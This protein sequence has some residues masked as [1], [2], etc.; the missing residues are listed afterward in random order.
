MQLA[1]ALPPTLPALILHGTKD[2]QISLDD[3]NNVLRGFQTAG[4]TRAA[5]FELANVDHVFK[6]VPGD[7][8]PT[9]EYTNPNLPFSHEAADRLTDFVANSF[10]AL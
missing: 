1:A 3:V 10:K 4:N 9:N 6:E 5:L 2:V 7:P 8:D